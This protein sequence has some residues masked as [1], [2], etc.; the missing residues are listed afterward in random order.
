LILPAASKAASVDGHV[1]PSD[2]Y[3]FAIA[4][5]TVVIDIPSGV[6]ISI[7]INCS[8]CDSFI[9]EIASIILHCS[10]LR[11]EETLINQI[12]NNTKN[13][14]IFFINKKLIID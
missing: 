12:K 4:S 3:H 7:F 13:N 14:N 11:F 8:L 1:I 5:E 2:K 6:G 10:L 9:Q